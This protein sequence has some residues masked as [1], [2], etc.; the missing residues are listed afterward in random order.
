MAVAWRR[1]RVWGAPATDADRPA[2]FLEKPLF[3]ISLNP[4]ETSLMPKVPPSHLK[5]QR[6]LT[7][8]VAVSSNDARQT[9]LAILERLPSERIT[10]DAMMADLD[11]Q[12]PE[13]SAIDR[14]LTQIIVF[15]VLRWRRRLD[16]V[17]ARFSKTKLKRIDP[18]VLNLL[19][20]GMF[21]MLYLDRVPVSAAVNTTVQM[22]KAH[23]PIWVVRFVN[24]LLREAS[25]HLDDLKSNFHS[26]HR[27]P[28]QKFCDEKSFPPWLIKR[29]FSRFGEKE[30]A[31]LCDAV[32]TIADITLRV[33]TLKCSRRQAIKE[34]TPLAD[35]VVETRCSP[36]G[37]RL[38]GLRRSIDRLEPF[39]SGALQVQDEA[40]QLVTLVLNPQPGETILDACA[41]LGGKTGHIAQMM[42]N[43][44]R[45]VAVDQ[46]HAKLK[47]LMREMDRMGFDCIRT[48]VRDWDLPAK[49]PHQFDRILIDA[50]C[51]GIGVMRRN[52]DI[53]WQN[54]K[55]NLMRYARRQAAFLSNIAPLV[56]PGGVIIYVVCS[57]EP[58]E[59]E[60]VVNGFL[61]NH[62]E[63]V[64]EDI[65][66]G[67]PDKLS[68]VGCEDGFLRTFP[69]RHAM[70]G[71]FAARI[72]RLR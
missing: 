17:I 15:G 72:R 11:H 63:F 38:T 23:A 55:S 53:K 21:Q 51:S 5:K 62:S 42:K 29:W 68:D 12:V 24:G 64:K 65:K 3:L 70:D 61:K 8:K 19:R 31:H 7:R 57:F 13:M 56:K 41:G 34:L 30:T 9:A 45:V 40:A 66:L 27:D 39:Q 69:H 36:W 33:N 22:T 16:A 50:P 49:H 71:F 46:S 25:R 1:G 59:N 48:Q 28:I 43:R 4:K 37:V 10:L 32:N 26:D 35:S 52:P 58:E 18:V 14:S 44:G 6:R 54:E 20:I 60:I 67:D 47:R 2:S